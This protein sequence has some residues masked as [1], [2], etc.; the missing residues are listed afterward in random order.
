[1]T[2]TVQPD[3]LD[4]WAERLTGLVADANT[5]TS[6]AELHLTCPSGDKGVFSAAASALH[7]ARAAVTGSTT[8]LRGL[9]DGAAGELVR[10]ASHYREADLAEA[11][12]LEALLPAGTTPVAGPTRTPAT[13]LTV[14]RN[15]AAHLVPPVESDPVPDAFE[16]VLSLPDLVSPTAWMLWVFENVCGFNPLDH[17]AA[18]VAGDWAVFSRAAEALDNLGTF[19]SEMAAEIRANTATVI[20]G[21]NPAWSGDAADAAANYFSGFSVAV[22]NQVRTTRGLARECRSF[23]IGMYQ[24]AKGLADAVKFFLDMATL[25]ALSAAAGT[26]TAYT[27]VGGVLGAAAAITAFAQARFAWI[28]V[29]EIIG[30]LYGFANLFVGAMGRAMAPLRAIADH[31]LPAGAYDHPHA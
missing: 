24:L 8:A 23:S 5:A 19:D 9:L 16:V 28:A 4:A 21:A 29:G 17:L 27:G 30:N 18:H 25:A 31:P 22:E 15:P 12:R 20:A 2:L 6:Y 1:M 11:T 14:G 7:D 10:T 3:R 13:A 26:F